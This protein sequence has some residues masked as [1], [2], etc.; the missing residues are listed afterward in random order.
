MPRFT[1]RFPRVP[2]LPQ[3]L[4]I[5]GTLDADKISFLRDETRSKE[6]FGRD[7]ERCRTLQKRLTLPKM[8]DVSGLLSSLDFLYQRLTEWTQ[9]G[10][11]RREVLEAFLESTDLRSNLGENPDQS[12]PYLFELLEENPAVERTRKL[13]RLRTGI[14]DNAVTFSSF[15]DIRPNYT[16]DRLSIDD[17]VPV[18]VFEIGIERHSDTDTTCVFQL[19]ENG[20]HEFKNC[21]ADTINKIKSVKLDEKLKD[22]LVSTP[23][24]D[25]PSS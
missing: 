25:H 19:T 10:E 16:D 8:S 3:A 14:L 5:L 20:L 21:I 13:A 12:F 9:D 6:A 15:V 22:R 7:A 18:I 24:L 1:T 23:G 4:E 17:L 11:D 2:P